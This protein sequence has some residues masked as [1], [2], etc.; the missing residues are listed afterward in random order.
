MTQSWPCRRRSSGPKRATTSV[1]GSVS[2]SRSALT[3]VT[4]PTIRSTRRTSGEPPFSEPAWWP[5]A[6]SKP[7]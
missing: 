4:W 2:A 5:G 6:P 3:P 1:V 7:T